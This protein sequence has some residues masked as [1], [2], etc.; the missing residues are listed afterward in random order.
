MKTNK[1]LCESCSNRIVIKFHG[2]YDGGIIKPQKDDQDCFY[3]FSVYTL[4]KDK[5]KYKNEH[6]IYL[7]VSQVIVDQCSFYNKS[8][9]R[10]NKSNKEI[11]QDDGDSS[12]INKDNFTNGVT[13]T[14]IPGALLP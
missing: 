4:V 6:H 8:L 7:N 14:N 9:N 13:F 10:I 5:D 1:T 3:N 12:D 11:N 2:E